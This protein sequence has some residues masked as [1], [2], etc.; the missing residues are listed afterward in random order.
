AEATTLS[1]RREA[2][3]R[4]V[5]ELDEQLLTLTGEVDLA[6]ARL[7]A[8]QAELATKRRILHRR[9]VDI[10]KRGS[11][12]TTQVMLSAHSFGDLIARY[13]F[14][15]LLALHD[16][17]LVRRVEELRDEVT[18]ERNRLMTLRLSVEDSRADRSREEGRLRDLERAQSANLAQTQ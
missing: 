13:K 9:V 7:D 17:A 6:T 11:L 2:T 10:Y 12:F 8:A 18:S 3:A 4:T 15:H 16:R 14:L 1:R 5:R